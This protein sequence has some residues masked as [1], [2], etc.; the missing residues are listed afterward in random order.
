MR[1][2][3]DRRPIAVFAALGLLLALAFVFD[4]KTRPTNLLT[5]FNAFYCAGAS[6]DRGADPYLTEPLGSCE[7]APRPGWLAS[8]QP[9][10]AIP[11]PLPPY[12]LAAFASIAKLPY[13]VAALFW[14]SLLIAALA[15]TAR[16]LRE[17][18][19]LPWGAVVGAIALVD[20]YVGLA[21]GQVAP[22]AIAGIAMAVRFLQEDADP[23]AGWAAS[24]AMLE[25]HVGL[26]ACLALFLW[27]PRTRL[28]LVA[29]GALLAL[30]SLGAGGLALWHEYFSGVLPAHRPPKCK[31]SSS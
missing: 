23:A 31:T 21:L 20:G 24:I 2:V 1:S 12:A 22:L 26:P 13:P 10:L 7:R 27:R 3:A 9:G 30:A 15:V 8:S 11:A 16:G 6:L 18:T 5:D 28:P 4:P 25:P 14:W 29:A 19:G 17:A